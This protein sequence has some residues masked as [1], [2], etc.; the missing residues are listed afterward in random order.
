MT[1]Y[2]YYAVS[3]EKQGGVFLDVPEKDEHWGRWT[4]HQMGCISSL[5]AFFEAN[6]MRLPDIGFND[7][8]RKFRITIEEVP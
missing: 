3:K 4:G 8:P 1:E 5:F 7:E 2:V 6:G